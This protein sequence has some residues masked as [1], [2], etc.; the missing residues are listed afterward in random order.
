MDEAALHTGNA[1]ALVNTHLGP[2]HPRMA[3]LLA[4]LCQEQT[5]W[6]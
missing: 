6:T 2:D 3:P 5:I 4:R 1:I